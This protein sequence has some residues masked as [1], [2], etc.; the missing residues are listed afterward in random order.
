MMYL[1]SVIVVIS[2]LQVACFRAF[3]RSV[4]ASF[5]IQEQTVTDLNLEEMQTMFSAASMDLAGDEGPELRKFDPLRFSEKSPEWVP[6]FRES[7]LKHGRICMLAVVGLVVAEFVRLPGDVFQSGTVIEAHNNMVSSGAMIQLLLWIGLIEV[8]TI[9]ALKALGKSDRAPGNYGFDPLGL[10][11]NEAA[12]KKYE[13]SELK[14]G[15]LAMLAF[16][17]MITQAV[18]TGKGFPY[19]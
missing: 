10:G 15:R 16:S 14:N 7:E 17:G 12:F 9:P 11:K 4:R 8:I 6:W 5:G 13:V 18:L 1:Q 3:P 2:F 19:V